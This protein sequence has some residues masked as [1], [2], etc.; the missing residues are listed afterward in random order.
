[1]KS[2]QSVAIGVGTGLLAVW[3]AY[4]SKTVNKLVRLGQSETGFLLP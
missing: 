4:N 1:M 2:W 3:L